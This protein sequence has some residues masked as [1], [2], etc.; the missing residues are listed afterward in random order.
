MGQSITR[1]LVGQGTKNI[2]LTSR[3]GLDN[4]DV[5]DLVQELEA[6]GTK[7]AVLKCDVSDRDQVARLAEECAVTMPPIKGVIHASAVFQVSTCLYPNIPKSGTHQNPSWPERPP[8]EINLRTIHHRHRAQGPRRLEFTP[9]LPQPR[10]LPH[11]R[12]HRLLPR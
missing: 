6:L 7:I 4:Q 3:S 9:P 1:W 8:R 11:V 5:R 2:I 10:L 12:L